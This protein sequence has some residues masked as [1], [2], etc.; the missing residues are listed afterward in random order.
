MPL[1]VQPLSR[2]RRF[3]MVLVMLGVLGASLGL[4]QWLIRGKAVRVTVKF[5]LPAGVAA[6]PVNGDV[7]EA[8]EGR[9]V[10]ARADW[11]EGERRFYAFDFEDALDWV[12]AQYL[13]AL[14]GRI[15]PEEGERVMII[16]PAALGRVAGVES[17]RGDESAFAIM[18][19][20]GVEGHIVAFCLSGDGGM[21]DADKQFFEAYCAEQVEIRVERPTRR[22]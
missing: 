6:L 20:A 9:L 17:G 1:D 8:L 12:P 16:R 11:G 15:M 5:G 10:E 3:V 22:G 19:L 7:R 14:L 21:T 18:R 13:E 2:M 4:A